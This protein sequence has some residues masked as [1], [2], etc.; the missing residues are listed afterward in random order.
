LTNVKD[1]S[2]IV[3]TSEGKI[4]RLLWEQRPRWD[5]AVRSARRLISRP[6]KA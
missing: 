6:R 3:P 5:P 1:K 4:R 2:D